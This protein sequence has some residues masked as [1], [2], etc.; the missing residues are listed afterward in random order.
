MIASSLL[1][2]GHHIAGI[3]DRVLG[4]GN[5]GLSHHD[6]ADLCILKVA[7]LFDHSPDHI[8][9]GQQS[10]HLTVLQ[11]HQRSHAQ[12]HQ[13]VDGTGH[14]IVRRDAVNVVA[15]KRED[16]ANLHVSLRSR[17]GVRNDRTMGRARLRPD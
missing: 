9:L 12:A 1:R 5:H 11:Y 14:R 6:G 2:F 15:F 10:D 8:A 17:F 16:F 4:A 3:V 7:P 13:F